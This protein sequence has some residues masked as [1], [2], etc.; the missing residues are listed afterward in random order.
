MMTTAM[1]TTTATTP[2]MMAAVLSDGA[3]VGGRHPGSLKV[4]MATGQLLSTSRLTPC[5]A[6]VE[7]VWETKVL[8]WPS[9]SEMLGGAVPWSLARNVTCCSEFWKHWN[10]LSVMQS[11]LSPHWQSWFIFWTTALVMFHNLVSLAIPCTDYKEKNIQ[12]LLL[13]LN[14][15]L[16]LSVMIRPFSYILLSPPYF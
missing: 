4:S 11:E 6:M 2:P 9:S 15:C 13:V 1:T 7:P 16:G 10:V 12:W 5:T 3:M 8:K 14:K